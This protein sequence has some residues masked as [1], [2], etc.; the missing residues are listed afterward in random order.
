MEEQ[1]NMPQSKEQNESPETDHKEM[2]FHK[3]LMKNS[4]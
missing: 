3:L 2:E 4:K 1:R